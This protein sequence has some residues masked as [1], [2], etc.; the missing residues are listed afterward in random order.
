MTTSPPCRTCRLIAGDEPGGPG[1]LIYGDELWEIEHAIEP[2]PLLG[3][4]VLRPRRHVEHFADLTPEEALTFGPLVHRVTA[5]MTEILH[6]AKIYLSLYAEA[7]GFAHLHVHLIP[8]YLDTPD[9]HR[10]PRIFA[11]LSEAAASGRNTV[12]P[13]RAAAMC[14]QIAQRM[15]SMAGS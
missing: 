6:P 9:D 2:L 1:G 14:G 10:G 7:E 3:W 12:D 15:K 11:Y 8:R 4:L 13:A 5:A